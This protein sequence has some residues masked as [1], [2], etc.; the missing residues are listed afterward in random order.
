[1]LGA[2]FGVTAENLTGRASPGRGRLLNALLRGSI[3]GGTAALVVGLLQYAPHPGCDSASVPS[4]SVR[5]FGIA[6]LTAIYFV[7]GKAGLSLAVVNASASAIWP[8]TGVAVAALLLFGRW[9]WPGIAIGA[10]AVNVA[11]DGS[12]SAVAGRGCRQHDGGGNRRVLV[13]RYANG[14]RVF[15]RSRDVFLFAIAAGLIAPIVSA[16]FGAGVLGPRAWRARRLS[17]WCGARGGSATPWARCCP[18]RP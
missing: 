3:A 6:L 1:M 18:R 13:T 2:A 12:R 5:A 15:E 4:L 16:S 7:A 11:D 17:G 9:L 10:F 8:P 14:T